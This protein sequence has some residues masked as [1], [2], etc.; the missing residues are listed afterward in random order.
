MQPPEP[1]RLAKKKT[2]MMHFATANLVSSKTKLA[3]G[4]V[5]VRP[6]EQ[7]RRASDGRKLTRAE[8]IVLSSLRNHRR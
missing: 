8:D 4:H 1:K 2:K 7:I 5:V 6:A 3:T